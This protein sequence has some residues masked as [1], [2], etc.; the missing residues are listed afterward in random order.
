MLTRVQGSAALTPEQ[1][2]IV[3]GFFVPCSGLSRRDEDNALTAMLQRLV[4][5]SCSMRTIAFVAHELRGARQGSS[6]HTE[7][8]R[9]AKTDYNNS[10]GIG[11]HGAA[12]HALS[13]AK[14][15][16][17]A[18]ITSVVRALSADDSSAQE[19]PHASAASAQGSDVALPSLRKDFCA[20]TA[21]Q[22]SGKALA[23]P[24]Q[25]ALACLED[26]NEAELPSMPWHTEHFPATLKSVRDMAWL[27]MEKAVLAAA[28]GM[29]GKLVT[30]P[31]GL[32]AT[33]EAM[34][35]VAPVRGSRASIRSLL[36]RL[37][38]SMSGVPD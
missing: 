25:A 36:L 32:L 2:A 10:S 16:V 27:E 37:A 5:A 13:A 9:A 21:G 15:A 22:H 38:D 34:A 8:G 18:E 1:A 26:S 11:Q 7:A 30:L 20:L 29:H 6:A 24:L 14:A 33:L 35:S 17:S 12:K 28:A 19:V 4:V 31:S 23:Q 3:L